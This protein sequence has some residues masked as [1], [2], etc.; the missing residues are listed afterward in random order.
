[1]AFEQVGDDVNAADGFEDGL[2]LLDLF[3]HGP[4]KMASETDASGMETTG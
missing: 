2:V 3:G 4:L 1:V